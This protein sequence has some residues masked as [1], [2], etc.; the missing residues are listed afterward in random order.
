MKSRIIFLSSFTI[1]NTDVADNTIR[2]IFRTLRLIRRIKN[3]ELFEFTIPLQFCNSI[4]KLSYK[5][6]F[7]F[8]WTL[9]ARHNSDEYNQLV[10]FRFE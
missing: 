9:S 4:N 5:L 8:D 2:G 10:L 3:Y 1:R 6:F 7:F